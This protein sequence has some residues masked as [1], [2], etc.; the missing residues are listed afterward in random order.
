MSDRNSSGHMLSENHQQIYE[1]ILMV[2]VFFCFV[3]Q[4][5]ILRLR[6]LISLPPVSY[7]IRNKYRKDLTRETRGDPCTVVGARTMKRELQGGRGSQKIKGEKP[8]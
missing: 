2:V 4:M 6:K 5:K 1:T 7:L 3:Q 8:G